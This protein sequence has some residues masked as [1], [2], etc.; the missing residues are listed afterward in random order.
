MDNQGRYELRMDEFGFR[1]EVAAEVA[2]AAG[3]EDGA[4]VTMEEGY[5]LLREDLRRTGEA[6]DAM[7]LGKLI[8]TVME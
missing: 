2:M 4:M 3:V 8:K 7:V 6:L 1:F 5:A